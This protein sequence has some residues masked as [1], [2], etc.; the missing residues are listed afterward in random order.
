[1]GQKVI[2]E[3]LRTSID[4]PEFTLCHI[5][6]KDT[7]QPNKLQKS[8]NT[9]KFIFKN[10]GDM[11]FKKLVLISDEESNLYINTLKRN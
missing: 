4:N 10:Y 1:M 3:N 6:C 8:I 7:I 2:N 11:N 9:C 5:I